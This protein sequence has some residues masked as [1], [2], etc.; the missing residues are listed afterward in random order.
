[1]SILG[2]IFRYV[3]SFAN[4]SVVSLFVNGCANLCIKNE[5]R[6]FVYRL[7]LA[8]KRNEFKFTIVIKNSR[9]YWLDQ[10]VRE[11]C[12]KR[13]SSLVSNH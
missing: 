2:S 1:M 10:Y 8:N 12:L 6:K 13:R 5:V 7:I 9:T 3:N 11:P 4:N